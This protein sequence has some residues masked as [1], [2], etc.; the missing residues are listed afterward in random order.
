V[1]TRHQPRAGLGDH[2]AL[3]THEISQAFHAQAKLRGFTIGRIDQAWMKL[4]RLK[5]RCPAK[6][7]PVKSEMPISGLYCL[8]RISSADR[9]RKFG[10]LSLAYAYHIFRRVGIEAWV[11]REP[12]PPNELRELFV[13]FRVDEPEYYRVLKSSVGISDFLGSVSR[14]VFENAPTASRM[15][16][17]KRLREGAAAALGGRNQLNALGAPRQFKRN[18]I[19]FND[20]FLIS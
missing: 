9:S 11:V 2:H 4:Q 15:R 14:S 16:I 17:D 6:R 19:H 5:R 8:G 10:Q 20:L 18:A 1:L 3:H 12:K 13:A 7:F